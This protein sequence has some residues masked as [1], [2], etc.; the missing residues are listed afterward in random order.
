MRPRQ[1]LLAAA[2]LQQETQGLGVPAHGSCR[3]LSLALSQV[4]GAKMASWKGEC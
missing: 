3:S 2:L 4:P 1:K